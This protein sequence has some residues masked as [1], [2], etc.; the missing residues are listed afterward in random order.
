VQALRIEEAKQMLETDEL[1][2]D[3]VGAFVGY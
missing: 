3:E 1:S 2:N